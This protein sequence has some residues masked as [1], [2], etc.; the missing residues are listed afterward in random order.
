MGAEDCRGE[1]GGQKAVE[2]VGERMVVVSSKAVWRC[3]G[4]E[5]G[6]V[7]L[8]EAVWGIRM[9]DKAVE[10]VLQDLFGC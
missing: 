5:I 10:V 3:N 1:I 8:A 7:E 4:V 2:E 9:E 6:I